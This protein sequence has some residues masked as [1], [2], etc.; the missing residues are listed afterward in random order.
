M[1]AGLPRLPSL[2]G[3]NM[4]SAIPGAPAMRPEET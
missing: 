1:M 2:A 4:H 3:S